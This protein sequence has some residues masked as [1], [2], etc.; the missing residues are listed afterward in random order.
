MTDSAS[1]EGKVQ[2][3]IAIM[4][5]EV[6]SALAPSEDDPVEMQTFEQTIQNA[7]ARLKRILGLS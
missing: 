2:R 3:A 7:M 1:A 4:Q 5:R 6:R